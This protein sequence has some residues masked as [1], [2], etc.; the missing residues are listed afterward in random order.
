MKKFTVILLSALFILA[1]VCPAAL[2]ADAFTAALSYDAAADKYTVSGT[3]A[4]TLGNIPMLL[5]VKDPSG[6]FY[7]GFQTTA[8]RGTDGVTFSFVPLSFPADA[9]SGEYTLCVTSDFYPSEEKTFTVSVFSVGDKYDFLKDLNTKIAAGGT[10]VCDHVSAKASY[11]SLKPADFTALDPASKTVFD[12]FLKTA[13]T[14]PAQKP[15]STSAAYEADVAQVNAA[16]KQCCTDSYYALAAAKLVNIQNDTDCA[17][18]L[19]EYYTALEIGKED[20]A[21]TYSEVKIDGYYK[22]VSSTAAFSRRMAAVTAAA[23][24]AG[25]NGAVHEAILLSAIETMQYTAVSDIISSFRALIPVNSTYYSQL[26]SYPDTLGDIYTEMAGKSYADYAAAAAAFDALAST[27]LAALPQGGSTYVGSSSSSS[28]AVYV[29]DEVKTEEASGGLTDL[30]QAEWAREAVLY[31]TSRNII[32]G[33]GNGLFAP[34]D[35]VTR[36]EFIK[37]VVLALGL[38]TDNAAG[39]FGDVASGAWYY[40]YA[41]AAQ[42]A[43]IVYG[44]SEGCFRPDSYI[45]RQDMAT[46]LYRAFALSGEGDASQ[47]SDFYAVADYAT[48]AV[49]ALSSRGVING[50]GD[51]SFA[52]LANATRAQAAQMIYKLMK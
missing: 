20:A 40:P 34:N 27:K 32:S 46:I 2:A 28:G 39:S 36:A 12:G 11:L 14:L 30:S 26:T 21:T 24:R 4:D 47:F 7:T 22:S 1:S 50:L 25:I 18:W 49:G 9:V 51:G 45:S 13:Y 5:S 3:L 37:I 43:G 23:D 6:S 38:S 44:D 10:G 48:A 42:Q 31:L 29:K 35:T 17:A 52:P 8:V 16:W 33:R 19:T 15:V 41:A